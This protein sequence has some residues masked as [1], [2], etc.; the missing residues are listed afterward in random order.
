MSDRAGFR[1]LLRLTAGHRGTLTLAIALTVSASGLGMLQ[2]LLVRHGIDSVGTAPLSWWFVAGIAGLFLVQ[3]AVDGLGLFLLERS[4]ERVVLGVRRRLIARL[5]RLR[6]PAYE[7]HRLGDLI[8][9]LSV[10]TTV[11]RDVVSTAS[12]Q[13]VAGGLTGLGTAVLMLLLD[14]VLFGMV[15]ATVSVAAVVVIALLG[16]LRTAGELTQRGV[17]EMTAD[18]ERALGAIRMV[19]A[20]RA[21]AREERRIGER[22]ESAFAAGV[23]AARLTSVMTPAVELAIRG[24]LLLVLL[25]GGARVAADATS[26]GA[27]VAFLLYATYLVVPL[28]S[29]LQGIG[30]VQRGMGAL[31]RVHEASLLPVENEAPARSP[32]LS[33]R[34]APVLE[35]RD[36]RFSYGNRPVLDGVSFRIEPRTSVALVGKSGAGKSTIFS[37]AEHFYQPL[38]GTIMLNGVDLTGMSLADCRS[39]LALVDQNVPVLHGTLRE[40]LV[41]AVPDA[42][43]E[44]LARVL[45]TVNLTELVSGLPDGLATQVGERGNMLSGGERQRVAIARA[46]LTRPE[47]LLLDE[48]TAHLDQINEHAL[49]TAL[50]RAGRECAL[51]VIAHRL[52]TV[53]RADRILVLDEGRVAAE[54]THDELTATCPLY[55][56]L[57]ESQLTGDGL[58]ESL[59]AE[60]ATAG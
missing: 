26:L 16:R 6:L 32:V 55:R 52:A 17:G 41:Y 29:L 58:T 33:R 30:L 42:G 50:E 5:L 11:L 25:V 54:G 14:P 18:L 2:P 28:I 60:A 48:P 3:A 44:E 47:L 36:V 31:Q 45:E 19:R 10:D 8:S 49:T 21:E 27:L 57:V 53:R 37:L 12:V 1:D 35:F 46:L 43:A 59:P 38:S 22:A 23:R 7:D 13:L 24:S 40:N 51:L 15:A 9:R 20:N 34:C 56:R 39:R 4:G